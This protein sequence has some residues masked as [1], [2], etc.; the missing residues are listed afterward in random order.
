LE[1]SEQAFAKSHGK[2]SRRG[3]QAVL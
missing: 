2:I 3:A 1:K